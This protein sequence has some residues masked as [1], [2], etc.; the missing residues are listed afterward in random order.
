M[1]DPLRHA[2]SRNRIE[3][4]VRHIPGFQGYLERE[5]RRDSDHLARTWIADQ[6]QHGKTHLDNWQRMLLD[7]GQIDLLPSCERLRTRIDTFQSRVRGAMRGYSG[8][9]DLVRVDES[10]LDQV[11]QLDM[12]LVSDTVLFTDACQELPDGGGSPTEKLSQVNRQL[13]ELGRRF[14][15]RGELLEG[16]M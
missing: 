1:I 7:A 4:I 2:E 12:G 9:F 11:Y 10:L 16:M 8:F 14:D 13:D 6:L 3:S 5:Y 15:K